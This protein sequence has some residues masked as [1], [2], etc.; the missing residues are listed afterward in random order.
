MSSVTPAQ[1]PGVSWPYLQLHPPSPS[2]PPLLA[3]AFTSIPHPCPH[4]LPDALYEYTYRSKTYYKEVWNLFPT[5]DAGLIF[6]RNTDQV[7]GAWAL[8]PGG[9]A[10]R[11]TWAGVPANRPQ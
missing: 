4:S 5:N 1:Q 3:P 8:R 2:S 9:T 7:R 10:Y 6:T 11:G